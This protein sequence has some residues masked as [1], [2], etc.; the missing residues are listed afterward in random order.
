MLRATNTGAT[1]AIDHR[2]VVTQALVPYERAVLQASVQGREALTP[3][4]RWVHAAGLVPLCL[5][6]LAVLAV[7]WI[8]RRKRPVQGL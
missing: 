1:V 6:A 7:A 4:A 2:G 3:F 8:R 5:V